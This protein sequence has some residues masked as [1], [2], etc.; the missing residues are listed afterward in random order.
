MDRKKEGKEGRL[1]KRDREEENRFVPGR[2]E[3]ALS[4]RDKTFLGI[5]KKCQ[6]RG[7]PTGGRS[8]D[9]RLS[10]SVRVQSEKIWNRKGG[11]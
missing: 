8:E 4:R 5:G 1:Q 7:G 3:M 10:V 6:G 2:L 11:S 9:L